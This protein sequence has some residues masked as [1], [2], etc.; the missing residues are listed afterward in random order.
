MKA[1]VRV[2][3]RFGAAAAAFVLL[4]VFGVSANLDQTI[5]TADAAESASRAPKSRQSNETLAAFAR[6]EDPFQWMEEVDGE[7]PLAWVE[8]Q[9]ARS[10]KELESDPR[11]MTLFD[12]GLEIVN[13]RARIPTGSLDKGWVYNFWQDAE[14]VRGLWRRARL[15]SYLTDEP[16]WETLLDVDALATT[17][18]KNW[19][20]RGAN[21]LEP[22]GRYCMVNLS[23]GGKDAVTVREY[24]REAGVFVDKGFV[25]P[26][27]KSSLAWIDKDHLLVGT[28]WGDGQV[29]TSGYA[30]TLRIWKRGTALNAA[31]QVAA[32]GKDETGLWAG[33]LEDTDGARVPIA[34]ARNTFFTT[35][36]SVISADGSA[37]KLPLP[38]KSSPVGLYQGWLAL[39]LEQDWPETGFKQGDLVATPFAALR[40]GDVSKTELILRPG[41][42]DSIEGAAITKAGIVITRSVN[43]RSRAAIATRSA[44]GAWTMRDVALP[45][46]GSIG[47]FGAG[48][49]EGQIF[50]SFQDYLTPS[51]VYLVDVASGELRKIK[52]LQ[53]KFNADGLVVEQHEATSRDGTKVPYFLVRRADMPF[54]STTPTLL[55]AYG[56]FQISQT[57]GYSALNGKMWLEQGGAYVVANIRGGGEFGPAWHQAGLKQNRQRIYD[58]FIAVGEDLIARKVTAP[59][60]LGIMGGSNGGLLMGVMLTQRPDLWNAVV[61]QVPLLDMIRYH[62][63]LAG[64]SWIDEYGNP[65][66]PAER[67]FLE[68]ISPYQ[69]LEGGKAY[70]TPFFVTSTKDDRV[71]PGHARKMAAKM[72]ALGLPFYY[73]ENTDGGHAAAAN[74]KETARRRAL[75][76]VYLM[77][78]LGLK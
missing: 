67:A 37:T 45:E 66:I 1:E 32:I 18:G 9:N 16:Q 36:Y 19:V 26:E 28:D 15:Q 5:P 34:V 25:M 40:A 65:D 6:G 30:S 72:E 27:A 54:D 74:L 55:Y 76:T 49:Q 39:T 56:G 20:W 42:R 77:Q 52:S 38:P 63:L 73:Y 59:K 7:K 21:C 33:D 12:A 69:N 60:H 44:D 24:D 43:V 58:D 2:T 71:H 17:E 11:F 29:T 53:P 57:P 61:V 48:P 4:G 41:A 62:K 13:D 10:L 50:A 23:D 70:P 64:A 68:Q 3:T 75:E 35:T 78:R 31:Q 22:E 8:A 14:H 51:S 46:T 47:V